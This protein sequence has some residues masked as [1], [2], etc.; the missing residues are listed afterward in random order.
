[1]FK[2]NG[3]S[4]HFWLKEGELTPL[5]QS[6]DVI[7]SG[8]TFNRKDTGHQWCAVLVARKVLPPLQPP[9]QL[10]APSRRQV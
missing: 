6:G 2:A 4:T 3:T 8:R 7:I 10:P 5:I 9:L 1:M